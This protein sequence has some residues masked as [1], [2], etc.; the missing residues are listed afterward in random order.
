MDLNLDFSGVD[1]NSFRKALSLEFR[2]LNFIHCKRNSLSIAFK[3]VF[4]LGTD[5]GMFIVCIDFLSFKIGS[6]IIEELADGT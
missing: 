3:I 2:I 6:E 5:L 4:A 1:I